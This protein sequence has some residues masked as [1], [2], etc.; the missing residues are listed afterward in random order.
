[1]V[2]HMTWKTKFHVSY[3]ILKLFP[4]VVVKCDGRSMQ[5]SL[6]YFPVENVS[7]VQTSGKTARSRPQCAM[8]NHPMKGH[9]EVKD[10]TK[11]RKRECIHSL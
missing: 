9:K 7:E 8:C 5:L 3:I 10:C 11:N 6:I 1:M 4:I 2:N